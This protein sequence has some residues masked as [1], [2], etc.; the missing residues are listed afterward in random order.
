MKHKAMLRFLQTQAQDNHDA[1]NRLSVCL[2]GAA[3]PPTG[4]EIERLRPDRRSVPESRQAEVMT[5]AADDSSG[6]TETCNAPQC[7]QAPRS[8]T[9]PRTDQLR[10]AECGSSSQ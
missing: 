5:G 7:W 2:L 3:S 6:A 9:A 10:T 4:M 8:D 1:P